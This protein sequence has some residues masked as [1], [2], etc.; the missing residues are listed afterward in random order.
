MYKY[1]IEI[2]C[3]AQLE[4]ADAQWSP[5]HAGS[6]AIA[7]ARSTVST[8]SLDVD[9]ERLIMLS[10]E[11]GTHEHIVRSLEAGDY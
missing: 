7:L 2:K 11:S 10:F 8:Q 3:H 1:I 5:N 9:V 4:F 6:R